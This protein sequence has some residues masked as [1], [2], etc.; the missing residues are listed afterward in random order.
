MRFISEPYNQ[1]LNNCINGVIL[2]MKKIYEK[3]KWKDSCT[4]KSQTSYQ[5]E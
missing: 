3:S 1:H 2:N 5:S 4:G